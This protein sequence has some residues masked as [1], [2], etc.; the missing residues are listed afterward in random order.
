MKKEFF[1]EIS[2]TPIIHNNK[3]HFCA[4]IKDI[5]EI[6]KAAQ[7]SKMEENLKH[8]CFFLL[9]NFTA[10]PNKSSL[11]KPFFLNP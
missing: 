9:V 3:K 6:K 8:N 7:F 1:V 10:L 2:L 5:T 11:C 4:F